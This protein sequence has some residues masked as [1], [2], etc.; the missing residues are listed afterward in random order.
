MYIFRNLYHVVG[1]STLGEFMIKAIVGGNG[2]CVTFDSTATDGT[3]LVWLHAYF[4][5]HC[6]RFL[7]NKAEN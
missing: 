2:R 6:E 4:V 1:Q 5:N 3:V 7:S